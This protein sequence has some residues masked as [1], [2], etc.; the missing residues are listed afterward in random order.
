MISQNKKFTTK[1]K[2]V[3]RFGSPDKKKVACPL[4]EQKDGESTCFL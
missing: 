1:P 4:N 3:T 2:R